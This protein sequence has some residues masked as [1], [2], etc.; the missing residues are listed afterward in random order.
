[1]TWASWTTTGVFSGAGGV[2]TEEQGAISGDLTVHTTWTGT[3]AQLAVQ[4]TGSSEWFT[5]QG[6]PL[7]CASEGESRELHQR[8]VEAVRVGGV[9]AS[10]AA[11]PGPR[12][13]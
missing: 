1:M 2:L 4:Y 12:A 5:L 6:S 11:T 7:A 8:L 9:D 10:R 3:H 13:A